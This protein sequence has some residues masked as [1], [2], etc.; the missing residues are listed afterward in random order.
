MVNRSHAVYEVIRDE[1]LSNRYTPG[2]QLS[3]RVLSERFGFS[4]T[5]IREAFNRLTS[6]GLLD[7]IPHVGVFVRKLEQS[8]FVAMLE[9][10][11][12]LE[13]TAA[14]RLAKRITPEEAADICKIGAQV[15]ESE[16]AEEMAP[17]LD[18]ELTFHRRVVSLSGN[19]PLQ[20]MIENLGC[21]FSSVLADAYV[22]MES[23]EQ[24]DGAYPT[25]LEVAEAIAS[26]DSWRATTTMWRHF[27]G[28]LD[29]FLSDERR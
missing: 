25:H 21:V 29:Q 10:R 14:A 28:V 16:K 3:E 4:R 13:S 9:I 23:P 1:I 22:G 5:P 6:D 8:E 7:V 27:D 12:A 17:N 24:N 2:T 19:A 26:K 15:D 18:L 20:R 11:R